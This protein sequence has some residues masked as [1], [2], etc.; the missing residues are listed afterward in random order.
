MAL[1]G[2]TSTYMKSFMQFGHLLGLTTPRAPIKKHKHKFDTK[3]DTLTMDE[4][5]A[6]QWLRKDNHC[7]KIYNRMKFSLL[8]KK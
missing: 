4:M 7:G 5:K 8:K 6:L 1:S 2:K 3:W